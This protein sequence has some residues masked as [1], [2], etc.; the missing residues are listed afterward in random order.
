M[1]NTPE[2]KYAEALVLSAR[3]TMVAAGGVISEGNLVLAIERFN[4]FSPC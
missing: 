4:E 2:D 1:R 3:A